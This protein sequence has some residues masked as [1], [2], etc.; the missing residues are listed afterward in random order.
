GTHRLVGGAFEYRDLGECDL[1]GILQP[2]R[3]WQV[4]GASQAVGRFEA[5]AVGG[6]TPFVGRE[7]EIQMLLD[8]WRQAEDGEGQVVLLSGE[9]GIGKSRVTQVLRERVAD[10]PHALLRYQ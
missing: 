5:R 3:A 4:T 1:K 10:E 2:V 9:P 7:T 8:R 6:L